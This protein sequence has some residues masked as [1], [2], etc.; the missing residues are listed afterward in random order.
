MLIQLEL[1]HI[2]YTKKVPEKRFISLLMPDIKVGVFS[3]VQD[4]IKGAFE[5]EKET[6]AP[7]KSD[8]LIALEKIISLLEEKK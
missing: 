4:K 7:K 5:E 6:A 1:W 3:L 8:E 2:T